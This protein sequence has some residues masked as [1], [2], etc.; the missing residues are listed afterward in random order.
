MEQPSIAAS[1]PAAVLADLHS[2]PPSPS[3]NSTTT[4][5][6]L[7]A[8]QCDKCAAVFYSDLKA[9][10][11]A[12]NNSQHVS[13]YKLSDAEARR[14]QI[15]RKHAERTLP[16]MRAVNNDPVHRYPEDLPS[17]HKV[18]D[19]LSEQDKL[20]EAE[21][22]LQEQLARGTDSP[23]ASHYMF[24]L[25]AM[26]HHQ[27]DHRKAEEMFRE[28]RRRRE[29]ELGSNHIST[30]NALSGLAVVMGDSDRF[31]DALQKLE[32][33]LDVLERE[34]GKDDPFTIETL[35]HLA[36]AARQC[37]QYYRAET[38]LRRALS[39]SIKT[40]GK[41]DEATIHILEAIARLLDEVGDY[42]DA[43]QWY[44]TAL[45]RRERVFG[46]KH[47][48]TI[49][50]VYRLARNLYIQSRVSEAEALFRRVREFKQ[51]FFE[52]YST[53]E[54]IYVTALG[55]K[56]ENEDKFRAAEAL[57]LKALDLKRKKTL[58][59]EY[60]EDD[61]YLAALMDLGSGLQGQKRYAE[62][63]PILER[64]MELSV[65]QHGAD[66]LKTLSVAQNLSGGY[67]EIGKWDLA[68]PMAILVVK[69]REK[70]LGK[71]D[72]STIDGLCNLV[73]MYK[74][75]V[76][77]EKARELAREGLKRIEK[78]LKTG[79]LDY[80]QVAKLTQY[81]MRLQELD[82]EWSILRRLGI[83]EADG[84]AED[85][86]EEE[87]PSFTDQTPWLGAALPQGYVDLNH[88]IQKSHLEALNTRHEFGTVTEIFQP[89]PPASMPRGPVKRLFT[90]PAAEKL[91]S[92]TDF[93]VSDVDEQLMIFIRFISPVKVFSLQFTSF[94][95]INNDDDE[96][97]R[98]PKTVKL[99]VNAPQILDFE[100]S[101]NPT[102]EIE[103]GEKD[104]DEV[105]GTAVVNVRF[106]KF[107]SVGT[108]TVFVVDGVDEE[109]D[110]KDTGEFT[111]LD[112]VRV[113]GKPG[114]QQ[115][116]LATL[117][118]DTLYL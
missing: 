22:A 25:A 55:V 43:E 56:L 88:M 38:L 107:Q 117:R 16:G 103:I 101:V 75:Q 10:H 74:E 60:M 114:V 19:I 70:H 45:K 65:Q 98:R 80:Q 9:E 20:D 12:A 41:N 28:V 102:Q 97:S 83:G 92:T 87:E 50:C 115:G 29:E 30:L 4:S 2:G 61:F 5:T 96:V 89:S 94:R 118:D 42:V 84:E 46:E 24:S 39:R 86:E 81:Q 47:R 59:N 34:H 7:Y 13:F 49:E 71:T 66:D 53:R 116:T 76:K 58:V 104:W 17:P 37:D 73:N 15:R 23:A 31:E 11:H 32:M 105:T 111:R 77:V 93:I 90:Q 27:K 36:K 52:N 14:S 6:V 112:R 1:A 44:R 72:L 67:A 78:Q 3:Q 51:R 21:A 82:P 18:S 106:V 100:D 69:G 40:H 54:V 108:L 110:G 8:L 64:A 79:S 109:V 35:V 57:Y 48:S 33:V 63:E 91:K 85:S 99:Y 62:A 26:R 113:I 95:Y 68:E